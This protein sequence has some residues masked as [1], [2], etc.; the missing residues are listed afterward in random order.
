MQR[1]KSISEFLYNDNKIEQSIKC[2]PLPETSIIL[3]LPFITGPRK[4]QWG[5][6]KKTMGRLKA[7]VVANEILKS[8]KDS[9]KMLAGPK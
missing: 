2:L 4:V 5:K 9:I 1:V 8:I 7:R 6:L 3:L